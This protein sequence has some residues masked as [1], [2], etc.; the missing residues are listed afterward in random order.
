MR[1]DFGDDCNAAE[2]AIGPSGL[3]VCYRPEAVNCIPYRTKEK[4]AIPFAG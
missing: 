4:K 1:S 2:A 3:V